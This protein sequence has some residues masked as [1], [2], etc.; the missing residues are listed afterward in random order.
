MSRWDL[1][2]SCLPLLKGRRVLVFDAEPPIESTLVETFRWKC[3]VDA[4]PA[5]QTESESLQLRLPVNLTV[6]LRALKM[7]RFMSG[8]KALALQSVLFGWTFL[9]TAGRVN[10]LVLG[11]LTNLACGPVDAT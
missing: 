5:A 1:P 4:G 9:M 8:L 7:F 2:L 11:L 6:L 3:Y 10:Y